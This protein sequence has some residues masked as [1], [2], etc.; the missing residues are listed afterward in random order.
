MNKEKKYLVSKIIYTM[1]QDCTNCGKEICFH[2]STPDKD[3]N[4]NIPIG[5]RCPHCGMNWISGL[6]EDENT[7]VKTMSF[8]EM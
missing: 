8:I 4:K 7:T 6:D 1:S 5:E 3:K 2:D